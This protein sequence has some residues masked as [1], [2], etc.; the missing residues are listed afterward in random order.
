MNADDIV[1]ALR[2]HYGQSAVLVEQVGDTTGYRTRRH[3][4]VLA[5]GVWPSRG[6]F[7][8][9]I[10]VKTTRN[11]LQREIAQPEKA[12]AIAK[13]CDRM[14]IAAPKGVRALDLVPQGWGLLQVSDKGVSVGKE[15][16]PITA[17]PLDRGF[18][19]AVVRAT[20]TQHA[21]EAQIQE[22]INNAVRTH[23]ATE[24]KYGLQRIEAQ[25]KQIEDL[26]KQLSGYRR[27]LGTYWN[28]PSL[29]DIGRAIETLNS[30][31]GQHGALNALRTAASKVAREADDLERVVKNW[32]PSAPSNGTEH[33]EEASP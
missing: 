10:E 8:H 33:G 28:T 1:A 14:F 16:E 2:K 32:L 29:A 12:E 25:E 7:V 26:Q 4:D 20:V 24:E 23:I 13:Y 21:E 3:I 9:A 19:M 6:L 31:S 22:R 17:A 27:A 15:A 18:L 30:L 5:L 11:D